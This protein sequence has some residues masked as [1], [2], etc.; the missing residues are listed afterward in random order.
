[1]A[2]QEQE[3]HARLALAEHDTSHE[4]SE[5]AVSGGSLDDHRTVAGRCLVCDIHIVR[6]YW[7]TGRVEDSLMST[8]QR[9]ILVARAENEPGFGR[10]FSVQEADAQDEAQTCRHCPAILT[11]E[12]TGKNYSGCCVDCEHVAHD[13]YV[14]FGRDD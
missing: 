12:N 5:Y 11:E 6:T 4:L 9:R 13:E 14:R 1:M 2:A 7:L 8:E 10:P 3:R